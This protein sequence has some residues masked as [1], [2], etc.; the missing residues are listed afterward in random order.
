MSTN[1]NGA[2]TPRALEWRE[3]LLRMAIAQRYLALKK[4]FEDHKQKPS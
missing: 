1:T 3:T 4:H 2:F